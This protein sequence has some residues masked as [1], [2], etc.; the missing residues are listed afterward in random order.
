[1]SVSDRT[2][3]TGSWILVSVVTN[4]GQTE[5]TAGAGDGESEEYIGR[6]K[7]GPSFSNDYET[8]ESNFKEDDQTTRDRTHRSSDIEMTIAQETGLPT[9]ET[10]GLQ[11]ATTKALTGP[12]EIEVMRVRYYRQKP[13]PANP[14]TGLAQGKEFFNVEWAI[15]ADNAEE[16]EHADHELTGHCN[17]DV[18]HKLGGLAETQNPA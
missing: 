13:D 15:D 1:M 5:S 14:G 3:F 12:N 7:E 9:L 18:I 6:V 11:D 2:T 10:L 4:Y 16:A 8:A 17:G